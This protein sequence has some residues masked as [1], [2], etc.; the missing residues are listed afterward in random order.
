MK[1]CLALRHVFFEDLGVF[2]DPLCDHGYAIHYLNVPIKELDPEVV[3]ATDLLVVLGGPVGAGQTD[4]Y[5]WLA[6]EISAVSRR[7]AARRPTLGVCLGAQLMATALG[8]AIVSAAEVELGWSE[9][10]LS[11]EGRK[12]PLAALDSHPVLHWHG[13]RFDLPVGAVSLASTPQCPHQ[14]FAVG[15]YALALQFHAE[16]DRALFEHWLVGN[17]AELSSLGL[18]PETLRE[19]TR[20][21]GPETAMAARAMIGAW[22][23]RLGP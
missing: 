2:A 22:L 4:R 3:L 17:A 14:A 7:L 19:A 18:H 11:H 6:A 1:H 12:S 13:D 23:G 21:H 8:A 5:P 15:D 10:V 16:I 20:R 9:L